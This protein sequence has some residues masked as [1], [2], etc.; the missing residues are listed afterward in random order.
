VINLRDISFTVILFAYIEPSNDVVMPQNVG[1]F[2]N[3]G[4]VTITGGCKPSYPVCIFSTD[5]ILDL[6]FCSQSPY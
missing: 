2:Q 1:M 6:R 3:V 5:V 4:V